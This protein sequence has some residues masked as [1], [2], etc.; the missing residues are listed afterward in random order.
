MAPLLAIDDLNVAFATD[1]GVVQAVDGMSLSLE[2]GEIIA[3]VGESGSGKSVSAMTVMGL[4][5][6][7]NVSFGGSI[8]YR[9]EDLLN[10]SDDRLR[11]VR[12]AEIAMIF[13]DPMTSLNPVMR[14]GDQIAEQILAHEA[15]PKDEAT[16][17]AVQM[18]E[19][20]G[21][22]RARDRASNYPHEFSG[23]MRQ[24]VMIA[25]ALSCDPSIL[26]A[27]EPSTA[28]DVTIQAQILE[29]LRDL[30]QT[31]NAGIILVTHDLGVVADIAD[32][33]LVMYAGRIVEQGTLDEV[34]YNPQHPYTWGLLG[35]ITRL[36]IPPP[37][38]LPSISGAPPSLAARPEG[39]H[40][41]PRCPHEFAKCAE[42]PPLEARVS[43]NPGH[44]DR[45][46]LSPD[47]KRVKREVSEDQ[48]GLEA[49][50]VIA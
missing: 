4:T 38:R 12:G 17:R 3:V 23:G 34:F 39:C 26:I 33:V 1:E 9:G 14:V 6:G 19:R 13:Q 36:D 37:P 42:D 20:V 8:E 27:D 11:Q 31:A 28:L 29:R 48:I 24:R 46:W 50:G 15:V 25:M 47:D 5:R 45:C 49:K 30:R 40:F 21:I 43:G 32:R 41:R 7:P 10:A 44:C 18:L 35:S 2:P 22:P 16:E